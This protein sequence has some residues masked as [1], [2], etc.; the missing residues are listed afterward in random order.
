MTNVRKLFIPSRR[1]LSCFGWISLAAM[2][3][4]VFALKGVDVWILAWG[5]ILLWPMLLLTKMSGGLSAE[6]AF[7][8][9][10]GGILVLILYWYVVA[11]LW[12][13]VKDRI[14]S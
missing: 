10:F 7:I 14:E 6:N 2:I 1:R 4:A 12:L 11:C 9:G 13:A 8:L 3:I 5:W